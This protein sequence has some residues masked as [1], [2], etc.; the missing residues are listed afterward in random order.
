MEPRDCPEISVRNYHTMQLEILK[1]HRY[2]LQIHTASHLR[3]TKI[4]YIRVLLKLLYNTTIIW[5][6]Q[7]YR[8]EYE[9]NRTV[10]NINLVLYIKSYVIIILV[11]SGSA[12]SP[13]H[14]LVSPPTNKS[15]KSSLACMS[16]ISEFVFS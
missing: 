10:I 14:P 4:S 16:R 1:G 9:G 2:H 8:K 12:H 6:V 5:P 3:R 7:N 15:A 13:F 11:H